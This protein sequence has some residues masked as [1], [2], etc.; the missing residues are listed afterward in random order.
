MEHVFQHDSSGTLQTRPNLNDS[1]TSKSFWSLWSRLTILSISWR[2]S[3]QLGQFS[4]CVYAQTTGKMPTVRYT[5]K[6]A[7]IIQEIQLLGKQKFTLPLYSQIELIPTAPRLP[8]LPILRPRWGKGMMLRTESF[9]TISDQ[10]ELGVYHKFVI[11]DV[12]G[13]HQTSGLDVAW[14]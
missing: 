10:P 7:A 3:N 14:E 4:A 13:D 5:C 12:D 1:A 6:R 8:R 2:V 11:N 9:L